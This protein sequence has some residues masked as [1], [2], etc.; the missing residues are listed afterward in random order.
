MWTLACAI[1][2]PLSAVIVCPT[3]IFESCSSQNRARFSNAGSPAPAPPTV[4]NSIPMLSGITA[5]ASVPMLATA[6]N[7]V[8]MSSRVAP[9][10][11]RPSRSGRP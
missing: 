10:P 2:D 7:S 8:A 1:D 5:A 3:T 4:G 11:Y 9:G 6:R